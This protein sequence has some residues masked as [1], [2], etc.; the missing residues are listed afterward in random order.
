MPTSLAERSERLLLPL[1]GLLFPPV[2]LLCNRLMGLSARESVCLTCRPLLPLRAGVGEPDASEAPLDAVFSLYA[3]GRGARR[4]VHRI[5]LTGDPRAGRWLDS[6]LLRL[7]ETPEFMT[8]FGGRFDAVVPVPSH[9]RS[10]PL[11]PSGGAAGLWAECLASFFQI[12]VRAA[13]VRTR[14]V[15]KQTSLS[16]TLRMT[17]SISTLDVR[18]ALLKNCRSVL[19]ADDVYTTGATARACAQALR[20]AGIPH[21]TAGVI[22][23]G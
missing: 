14:T 21:V 19:L 4:L 16:R 8:K 9:R 5:K 18:S 11:S 13:L 22:A 23:R 7:S 2:C 3:Y 6:E 1:K 10:S 15:P 12:P 17:A 20:S